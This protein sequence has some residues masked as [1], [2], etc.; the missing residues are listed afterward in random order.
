MTALTPPHQATPARRAS[1]ATTPGGPVS[2]IDDAEAWYRD[3]RSG[4]RTIAEISTLAPLDVIFG[5]HA[6]RKVSEEEF[7]AL[8]AA[9]EVH[10]VV[11]TD[12]AASKNAELDA[13]QKR[14]AALV[15]AFKARLGQLD[16]STPQIE[17]GEA[18]MSAVLQATQP[19]PDGVGLRVVFASPPAPPEGAGPLPPPGTTLTLLC[20][21]YV[22]SAS[23]RSAVKC[24]AVFASPALPGEFYCRIVVPLPVM[25]GGRRRLSV[26]VLDN[27]TRHPV[28]LPPEIG[29]LFQEKYI[30]E[31]HVLR[32]P[33]PEAGGL[34]GLVKGTLGR[35]L[36]R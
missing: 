5:W 15:S 25:K 35:F 2:A 34:G 26:S 10:E 14:N 21:A 27:E 33:A 18:D 4:A 3:L 20:R 9:Q 28:K 36:G 22:G 29:E 8:M 31:L 12:I 6:Q 30:Q 7:A 32:K 16:Q 11:V 13:E 17:A 24:E 1:D 23:I 19:L